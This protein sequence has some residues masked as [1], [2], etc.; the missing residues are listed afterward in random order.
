MIDPV[1]AEPRDE[2]AD[3]QVLAE[4]AAEWPGPGAVSPSWIGDRWAARLDA[5][6]IAA[7]QESYPGGIGFYVS[8]LLGVDG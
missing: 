5:G 3:L 2:I 4:I 1:P 8:K 7:I 6:A